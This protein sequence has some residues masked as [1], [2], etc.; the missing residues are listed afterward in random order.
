AAWIG[1]FRCDHRS[2]RRDAA[3]RLPDRKNVSVC[4]SAVRLGR[5]GDIHHLC[6][7]SAAAARASGI[8]E[9]AVASLRARQSGRAS[10]G[11]DWTLLGVAAKPFRDRRRSTKLTGGPTLRDG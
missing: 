1:P 2:A 7:Q 5:G 8:A 10:F 11:L 6:A 3:R 9:G 4:G